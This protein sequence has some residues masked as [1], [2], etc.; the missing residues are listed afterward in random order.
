MSED[1]NKKRNEVLEAIAP[2]CAAFKIDDYDY[3]VSEAGQHETLRIYDTRIGC[4]CNS[5]DAVIDEFIGYLFVNT[6]APMA[7]Q[8]A[9]TNAAM[10]AWMTVS[11]TGVVSQGGIRQSNHC[12]HY[13]LNM[14]A[15][16]P[17]LA[18]HG[19]TD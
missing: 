4:S 15:C 6:N 11:I 12:F 7:A 10:K 1:L 13:S 9:K 18:C 16:K 5:I 19:F 8:P 2:I 14:S 17:W 3:I